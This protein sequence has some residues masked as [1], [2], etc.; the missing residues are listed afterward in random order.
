MESIDDIISSY[1]LIVAGFAIALLIG[2]TAL[3]LLLKHQT[4][5]V[6]KILF[7]AI[8]AVTILPTLFFAG[9]TIYLNSIS[10]SKGPV[11]WHADVEIWACGQEVNLK[12][13]KGFS[14]KIGTATLHEHNDKRVHLEGVV[15][16]PLDASLGKFF[17]VI[18][19]KLEEDVLHVPTNDGV[20]LLSSG[21][22]CGDGQTRELQFFVYKTDGEY[23]TQEKLADPA[24][25][26]IS[27]ESN[28]PPGD[29]VIVELD[30]PKERTDR[31]CKSYTVAEEIG[32]L[33]GEKANN[34]GY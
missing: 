2:L 28:V 14:N 31:K 32:K 30:V 7:A 16:K 21:I 20:M 19:G 6:K 34:Y 17:H 12:D 27:D 10:S 9:S 24:S 8:V 5:S 26:V 25:Y 11:H 23:Y 22:S 18:G 15:V 13:P 33:K 4:S 29:C 3:S 1:S